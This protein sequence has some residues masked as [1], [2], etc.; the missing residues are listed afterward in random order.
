MLNLGPI[1]DLLQITRS[2]NRT[3][4]I[5][6]SISQNIPID[7]LGKPT[8]WFTYSAIHFLNSVNLDE[9]YIF[10]Y[11]SGFSTLYFR[12]RS[13]YVTSVEDN[14]VW[15]D[16]IEAISPPTRQ[17]QILLRE[18]SDYVNAPLTFEHTFDLIVVDGS[19]REECVKV[20]IQALS[21]NGIIILDNSDGYVGEAKLL[22]KSGFLQIPFLGPGPMSAVLWETSLFIKAESWANFS[23]E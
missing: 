8:P 3:F 18:G 20:A 15:K 21:N 1:K 12:N 13:A 2:Q 23:S 22:R 10:E 14:H 11:G 7:N 6:N 4:G 16:R 5:V 19:F 9:K 17:S